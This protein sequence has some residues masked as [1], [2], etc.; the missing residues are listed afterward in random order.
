VEARNLDHWFSD[1]QS[2]L[3]AWRE[4]RE[5]LSTLSDND[6]YN[7]IAQWWKFVP[8]VNKTFDPWRMETWPNPWDLVA[9]GSFCPSAQGLGIF[10]SLVLARIDCEL[11]LAIVDNKARLLVILPDKKILNYIDGEVVDIEKTDL[12]I[13]KV[14]APSD[15][16]RLVK[17]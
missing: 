16:T 1:R 15:M 13:L 8:L 7:E 9:G 2:R 11:I 4:W 10:Y 12:Q 14:W 17:L 3:L 5:Q 6:L